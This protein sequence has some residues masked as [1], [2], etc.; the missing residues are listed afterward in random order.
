MTNGLGRLR[1]AFVRA[2]RRHGGR[3][4]L[5]PLWRGKSGVRILLGTTGRRTRNA[6]ANACERSR[7]HEGDDDPY[8]RSG[9]ACSLCG[10]GEIAESCGRRRHLLVQPPLVVR[11]GANPVLGTGCR[12]TTTCPVPRTAVEMHAREIPQHPALPHTAPAERSPN[13]AFHYQSRCP[14]V[15]AAGLYVESPSIQ[16]ENKLHC[17]KNFKAMLGRFAVW[18]M[19]GPS[20]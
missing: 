10:A 18:A 20:Q 16:P 14:P 1:A 15:W 3:E 8:F 9:S 5:Q 2:E 19:P 6:F 11:R 17:E 7:Q 12:D 13:P 4:A